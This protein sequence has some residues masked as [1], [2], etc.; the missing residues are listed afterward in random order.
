MAALRDK[1]DHLKG[2]CSAL[3]QRETDS[4]SQVKH[5]VQLVEQ[6]QLERTQVTV[7]NNDL[8]YPIK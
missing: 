1:N 8:T 2:H 4:Y 6:A 5:S 3:Q 7:V